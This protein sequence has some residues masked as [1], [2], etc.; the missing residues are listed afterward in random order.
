MARETGDKEAV[1]A[2]RAAWRAKWGL[3]LPDPATG[4]RAALPVRVNREGAVSWM[5]V[6]RHGVI[7]AGQSL[8][9][10][11]SADGLAAACASAAA[12]I[13]HATATF[14]L[15]KSN[16]VL[17]IPRDG[18]VSWA[19]RVGSESRLADRFAVE[20]LSLFRQH[21]DPEGLAAMNDGKSVRAAAAYN[22]FV[23]AGSADPALCGARRRQAI[24]LF[25]AFA[26]AIRGRRELTGVVD[27]SAPLVPALA[28]LH[29]VKPATVR[30][31]QGAPLG[32]GLPDFKTVLQVADCV[33]PDWLP[34]DAAGWM[35]LG[36]LVTYCKYTRILPPGPPPDPAAPQA[37]SEAARRGALRRLCT[38]AVRKNG[39]DFAAVAAVG[40]VKDAAGH[41]GDMGRGLMLGVVLPALAAEGRL[42]VDWVDG[43]LR[44]V[45]GQWLCATR[46]PQAVLEMSARHLELVS[47]GRFPGG[48]GFGRRE[49]ERSEWMPMFDGEITAPN[50]LVLRDLCTQDALDEE[51]REMHHCVAGYGWTCCEGRSRILS[52]AARDEDGALRRLSTAEIGLGGGKLRVLQNRA[53][54]NRR[55]AAAAAEALAWFMG[56][57]SKGEIAGRLR[58]IL[59]EAARAEAVRRA[60]GGHGPAGGYGWDDGYWDDEPGAEAAPP[61][62]APEERAAIAG[63][64]LAAACGFDWRDSAARAEAWL[65]WGRL[66]GDKA[67]HAGIGALLRGCPAAVVDYD[68]GCPVR[69]AVAD[70]AST[71]AEAA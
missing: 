26:A 43:D 28:R 62:L 70:Y 61:A 58:Y 47:G 17:P 16:G 65:H 23:G 36:R 24:A 60:L 69:R 30:A 49:G 51:G 39:R 40:S 71:A 10:D 8:A 42:P 12:I 52:I 21:L 50:G 33:P 56:A 4:F 59:A 15:W 35:A 54:F 31:A 6:D 22:Q 53:P 5:L 34:G 27:A 32:T 18:H 63:D 37:A 57:V 20:E 29:G 11:T 41:V 14:G 3:R 44:S 48:A 46:A 55:P 66:L 25:P 1:E 38:A 64:A 2:G 13:D 19:S 67:R 9:C 68:P 7:H 45:G